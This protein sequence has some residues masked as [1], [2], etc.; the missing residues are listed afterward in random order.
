M[1]TLSQTA[2]RNGT[3]N[4][5]FQDNFASHLHEGRQAFWQ[6][7]HVGWQNPAIN[8]RTMPGIGEFMFKSNVDWPHRYHLTY[9]GFILCEYLFGVLHDYFD[10]DPFDFTLD[11]DHPVIVIRAIIEEHPDNSEQIV[12]LD[13]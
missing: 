9:N 13:I 11:Y 7:G 3:T 4:K 12:I 10:V 5:N 1:A 8:V 2:G 6:P